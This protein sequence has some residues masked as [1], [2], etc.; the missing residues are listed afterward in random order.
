MKV[1]F[2]LLDLLNKM[3]KNYIRNYYIIDPLKIFHRNIP[4]FVVM[5]HWTNYGKFN[6]H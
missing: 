1:K 4:S 5:V 6:N 2:L 3:C